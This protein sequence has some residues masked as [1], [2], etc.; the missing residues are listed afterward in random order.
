MT[1][2]KKILSFAD[3]S[4]PNSQVSLFSDTSMPL[5]TLS[6]VS[7]ES[8]LLSSGIHSPSENFARVEKVFSGS[9]SYES[10]QIILSRKGKYMKGIS[11]AVVFIVDHISVSKSYGEDEINSVACILVLGESID[12]R[13]KVGKRFLKVVKDRD[14]NFS[15]IALISASKVRVLGGST[16]DIEAAVV[17]VLVCRCFRY[18]KKMS[19]DDKQIEKLSELT[20]HAVISGGA[21][22]IREKE[23]IC[24]AKENTELQRRET[25][26]LDG[27]N[28]VDQI[29]SSFKNI[30]GCVYADKHMFLCS[31]SDTQK[32]K[33]RGFFSHLCY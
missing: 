10:K 31:S 27:F 30:L 3:P 18:V 32:Y 20:A 6:E 14:R 22:A 9:L 7:E 28:I 25:F 12:L 19:F 29:G 8:S 4:S 13:T 24:T 15:K 11:A 5:Y 23:N 1:H 33:Q 17:S 2:Y 16:F 21:I 26:S